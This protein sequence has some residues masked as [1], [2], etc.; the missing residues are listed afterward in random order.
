VQ[1]LA[2]LLRCWVRSGGEGVVS[3]TPDPLSISN[4]IDSKTPNPV[5][6]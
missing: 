1:A 3:K 4:A 2:I 6:A 5:T